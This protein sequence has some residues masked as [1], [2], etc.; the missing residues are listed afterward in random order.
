VVQEHQLNQEHLVRCYAEAVLWAE[1]AL[2]FS[3]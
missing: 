1:A 2:H 3:S